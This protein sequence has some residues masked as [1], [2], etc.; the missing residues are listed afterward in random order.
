[1]SSEEEEESGANGDI[2]YF[3]FKKRM[4]L[5]SKQL[6]EKQEEIK[7]KKNLTHRRAVLQNTTEAKELDQKTES[8]KTFGK[9]S[10]LMMD[11]VAD[12]NLNNK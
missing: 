9:Q 3:S 11:L 2:E 1:M 7:K 5:K 6:R 8:K 4:Q 12:D 10:I